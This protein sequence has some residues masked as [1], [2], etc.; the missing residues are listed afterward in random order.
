MFDKFGEFDSAE[1]LNRAAAAQKKEG[2]Y[3]AIYALAKENGITKEEAEDFINDSVPELVSPLMAALGKLDIEE[4]DLKPYEIMKDWITY[5]HNT[6]EESR[7]MT[8]AVR[9][10][11]KSL[12]GCI[13]SLLLWSFKNQH[14]IDREIT[15]AAG[16]D[17][18]TTLGIPGMAKAKQLIREY[19]LGG[20]PDAR[21]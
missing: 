17:S 13:A 9:R 10:K 2:D 14:P 4:A 3:E 16:V 19:Y 12:K 7:A 8:Y 15:K 1:E 20:D 6:C 18:R 11:G 5:I 21:V